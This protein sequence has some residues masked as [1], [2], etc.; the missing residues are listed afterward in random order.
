MLRYNFLASVYAKE[1]VQDKCA[2]SQLMFIVSTA[3]TSD[4]FSYFLWNSFSSFWMEHCDAKK[5]TSSC[6]LHL[7]VRHQLICVPCKIY[8]FVRGYHSCKDSGNIILGDNISCSFKW[9]KFWLKQILTFFF[10]SWKNNS[11]TLEC[12]LI[13]NYLL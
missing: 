7:Y 12:K 8:L 3:F 5:Y 1:V 10:L 13:W 2:L 4:Y 9:N 6:N 11:N